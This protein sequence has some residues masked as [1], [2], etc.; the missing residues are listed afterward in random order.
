M[1][2]MKRIF[3]I[4]LFCLPLL[5]Q[6]Q[7]IITVDKNGHGNYN[8]VQAAF[9][10]IPLHNK[11]PVTI[12]IKNGMYREKLLLD[13]TKDFITII[14]EDKF[15]TILVYDDHTGKVSPKGDTINTRTSWSFKSWLIILQPAISVFK[16]TRGL[17]RDRR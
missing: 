4:G 3:L 10:S 14:G 1:K 5:G 13:S 15:N 12:N 16:T 8:S 7:K 11:K 2:S 9:N 17:Q 6:S